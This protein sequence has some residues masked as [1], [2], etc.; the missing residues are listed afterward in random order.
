M[1]IFLPNRLVFRGKSPEKPKQTTKKSPEKKE[2][3]HWEYLYVR[4]AN[5]TRLLKYGK[6][7]L[8]E[9]LRSTKDR[10]TKEEIKARIKRISAYIKQ[11]ESLPIFDSNQKERETVNVTINH[12]AKIYKVS[13]SDLNSEKHV[14][15]MTYKFSAGL[16]GLTSK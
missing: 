3:I 4:K 9:K 6:G 7:Q 16:S 10:E 12:I 5:L 13:E 15:M 2:K 8:G 11:V 14:D 1:N